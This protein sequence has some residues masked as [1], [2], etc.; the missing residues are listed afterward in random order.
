MSPHKGGGGGG[1]G[2]AS[3]Y[4]AA[5]VV[6]CPNCLTQYIGCN[7]EGTYKEGI[8]LPTWLYI[9]W[10]LYSSPCPLGTDKTNVSC[11]LGRLQKLLISA[12]KLLCTLLKMGSY[13]STTMCQYWDNR[14]IYR[15]VYWLFYW[16]VPIVTHCCAQKFITIQRPVCWVSC[17]CINNCL[18]YWAV[19]WL[20]YWHVPIVT[21][22]C[23][24]VM[25]HF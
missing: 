20:F 13:S 9:Y 14:L 21:H 1:G 5:R 17:K 6:W 22:C 3:H 16:H 4:S 19:Y 10:Y 23:A 7:L 15:E 11:Y 12:H 2:G 18:N 25:I 24:T 8:R